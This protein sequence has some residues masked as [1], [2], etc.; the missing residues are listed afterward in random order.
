VREAFRRHKPGAG[1]DIVVI[2]RREMLE[3]DYR[4]VEADYLSVLERR[5]LKHHGA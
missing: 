1:F 3:S 4:H 2:P 5:G